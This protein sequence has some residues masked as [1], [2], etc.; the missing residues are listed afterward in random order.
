MFNIACSGPV[1][2]VGLPYPELIL[3]APGPDYGPILGLTTPT[4]CRVILSLESCRSRGGLPKPK[5]LYMF[6]VLPLYVDTFPE[7]S[8]KQIILGS[9]FSKENKIYHQFC[10]HVLKRGKKKGVK[11]QEEL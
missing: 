9:T 5:V 6:I 4:S 7:A 2:E 1:R 8:S 3:V 11:E 10:L